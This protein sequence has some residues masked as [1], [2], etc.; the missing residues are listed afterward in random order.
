MP[1]LGLEYF[2]KYLDRYSA[3]EQ[4]RQALLDILP[5]VRSGNKRIDRSSLG[6]GL[7]WKESTG[8]GRTQTPIADELSMIGILKE[9]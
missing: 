5:K 3:K 7:I 9:R 1:L 8:N 4:M 2:H 6:N